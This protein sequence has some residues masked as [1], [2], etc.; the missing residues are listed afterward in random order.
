MQYRTSKNTLYDFSGWNVGETPSLLFSNKKY[1]ECLHCCF[2]MVN[3]VASF[4][5]LKQYV[6]DDGLLHE[7]LHLGTG[8]PISTHNLL[9]DLEKQVKTLEE[10]FD[11]YVDSID[12][13]QIK[14]SD[15]ETS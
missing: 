15:Y 10:R 5:E 6:Q 8:I 9:S 3:F 14:W 2:L 1:L 13:I 12:K 7:L 4:E 11:K